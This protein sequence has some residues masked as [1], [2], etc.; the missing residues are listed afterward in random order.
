[1]RRHL[2]LCAVLCAALAPSARG[3]D[4]EQFGF[5]ARAQAMG[6]AYTALASDGTATYW[7][8]A[9]LILSRHLNLT[10]GY[11]FADYGL[12][13]DS[14]DPDLDDDVE[15]IP[16]L[17]ALSLAISTTIPW[18]IPDRFAFGLGVFLPTRGI[19]NVD[20]S[21][22]AARP[23]WFAYG[24]RQD[25]VHVLPSLAVKATKW[26]S[27]GL[28]ASIFVDAAGGT[29]VSAGVATPVQPDFKLRLK[30]DAGVVMGLLLQP[31]DWL[32]FGLTYRSEL[33]FK[34]DFP[35]TAVVQGINIPLELETITFFT[36]HQ[37]SFGVAVSP[38]DALILTFDLHWFLWSTYDDPFLVV[39][40][41]VAATPQR[42]EVDLRD[43]F[44]PRLG[45]E[46][47]VTDWLLLR[48]GYAY[49]TSA[50]PSQDF[51]PTNLVD[52][53][54]HTLT[55]GVGFVFGKPAE[56]ASADARAKGPAA[57]TM[58]E[59]TKDASIDLD[60]FF[61]LHW[62]PQV[63]ATKGAGAPV[64]SW[65]ADGIIMNFGLSL[66]ARF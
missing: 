11:S 1:M 32:S 7:N 12:R 49:R 44:S 19:V 28:G 42:V 51:E 61:Q 53:E 46:L 56:D 40:S 55:T 5:G 35:A 54:R 6:N 10:F 13:F 57:Q 36:P 43:T 34:L 23:E 9:G 45:A 2:F 16:P 65:E 38:T 41:A 8:P 39:T 64:S 14:D 52:G 48:G 29:T 3:D 17:S 30:P 58:E 37:L 62:H 50:V 24:E 4:M 15:R 59:A 63:E 66:T 25:R 27:F 26:L 22:D 18:D 47:L 21:A 60:L 20:S 31:S 33:S